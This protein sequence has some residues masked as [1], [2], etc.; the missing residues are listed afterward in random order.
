[1]ITDS[2]ELIYYDLFKDNLDVR[3]LGVLL[4]LLLFFT[5]NKHCD[6]KLL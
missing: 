1:M 5:V 6:S 4:L 3:Y 2:I